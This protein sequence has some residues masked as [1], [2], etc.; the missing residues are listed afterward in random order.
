MKVECQTQV[1]V[2]VQTKKRGQKI[3]YI[4][5]LWGYLT[6][7]KKK[8]NNKTKNQKMNNNNK[9]IKYRTN[10]NC[11]NSSQKIRIYQEQK[12]QMITMVASNLLILRNSQ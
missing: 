4:L 1:P 10:K 8:N 3:I 7:K 2:K 11:N 6:K 9:M 12:K 5:N